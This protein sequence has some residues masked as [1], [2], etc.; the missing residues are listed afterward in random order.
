LVHNKDGIGILTYI[1]ISETS[2]KIAIKNDSTEGYVQIF[3]ERTSPLVYPLGVVTFV[4]QIRISKVQ[5]QN[6][7]YKKELYG[8]HG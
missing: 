3:L 5:G 6:I 7:A 4:V 1:P 2:A 8:H